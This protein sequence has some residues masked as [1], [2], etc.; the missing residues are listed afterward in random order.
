M[1]KQF[2]MSLKDNVRQF[3]LSKSPRTAAECAEYADLYYTIS[4]IGKETDRPDFRQRHGQAEGSQ[5]FVRPNSG[6]VRPSGNGGA[7]VPFRSAGPPQQLN[8]SLI[9]I[10][11]PTRPY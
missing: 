7:H 8:L 1:F 11:E 9:H 4:K 6:G 3:V 10:S 5:R 2:L